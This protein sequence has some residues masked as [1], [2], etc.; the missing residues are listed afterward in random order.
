MPDLDVDDILKTAHAMAEAARSAV[1]PF[2]RSENLGTANKLTDGYDPVTEADKG[3]ERA[4]RAVLAQMRPDDAIIGE[5]YGSDEGRSGLTWVLDPIDGTRAFIKRK[6]HFVVSVGIIEDG[7]CVA[8][9]LYNP[10]TFEAFDAH[11]QGG[12]ALNGKPIRVTD[13]PHIEGISMIGYDF[14]F[15]ALKVWRA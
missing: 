14:K 2:F 9:A 11:L 3:A 5:E 12:A 4:M 8:G 7:V 1:L 13:S 15:K 10:L 6:P